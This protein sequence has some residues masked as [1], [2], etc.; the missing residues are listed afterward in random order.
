MAYFHKDS[1]T[2]FGSGETGFHITFENGW[3]ASVQWG[4]GNYCDDRWT[5]RE[6]NHVSANAEIAAFKG[7]KWHKWRGHGDSVKGWM[8]PAEVVKF[9]KMVERKRP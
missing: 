7:D 5:P 2:G 9:L 4:S 3:T 6:P 1:K 8:N